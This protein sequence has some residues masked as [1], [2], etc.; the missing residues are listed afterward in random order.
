MADLGG[1]LVEAHD[2]RCKMIATDGCFRWTVHR[3]SKGYLR[4][5]RQI[6]ALVMMDDSHATGFLGKTGRGT[7]EYREV[8]GRV[9]ILT[10]TLGKALGGASGGFTSAR[11]QS[12][13]IAATITPVSFFQQRRATYCRRR[14]LK[15]LNF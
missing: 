11:Q 6:W 7:H 13:S 9:D 5:C 2:A 3:E 1:K 4:P 14:R 10:G 8:M 15:P 12:L